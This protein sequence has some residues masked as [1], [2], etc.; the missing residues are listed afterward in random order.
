V[1]LDLSNPTQAPGSARPTWSPRGTG[2]I[3][4]QGT[5]PSQAVQQN[6]TYSFGDRN[7][8]QTPQAALPARLFSPPEPSPVPR[9]KST[10]EISLSAIS[11]IHDP[12][13]GIAADPQKLA[14]SWVTNQHHGEAAKQ[15]KNPQERQN[16]KC[17]SVRDEANSMICL[18]HNHKSVNSLPSSKDG[19]SLA[20]I[21]H[22][23]IFKSCSML[24]AAAI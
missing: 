11:C 9:P 21:V 6:F 22:R 15:V 1:A 13:Y 3:G 5:I 14:A 4:L 10:T 16:K 19:N 8:P 24:A 23:L 12:I 17:Q 18:D 2:K 7:G 20:N